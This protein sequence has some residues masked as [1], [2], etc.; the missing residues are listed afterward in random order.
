[1]SN[2]IVRLITVSRIYFFFGILFL[3]IPADAGQYIKKS[4]NRAIINLN[5]GWLFCPQNIANGQT[6]QIDE[7]KFK[8]VCLPHSVKIVRH[9]NIDTSAFAIISWYRR[10]INIPAEYKDRCFFIEFQGVSKVAEVFVNNNSVGI[11]KGAYTQFILDIT[12]YIKIGEDNIIAVRVDSRQRKDIPPE[13]KNVDYMIFGGIV[14]DVS[15]IITDPVHIDNVFMSC[16]PNDSSIISAKIKI[17]NNS[18][19]NRNCRVTAFVVDT[20]DS[21]VTEGRLENTVTADSGCEFDFTTGQV[22]KPQLWHPDHPYLYRIFTEIDYDGKCID[23]YSVKFGVRTISFNKTDG[24]FYINGKRLMLRGLNR[25]ETYPFIGRAASNR[26]Q[27]KDAEI[28]KY[29]LGCNTIRCSHYPQDPEFLDRC[30]EIGLM[31]LDEMPG[32]VYVKESGEWQNI[33]VKNVEEM[34][35]RDRNH[36]SI[37]SFGVRINESADFHKFY[38]K[39]NRISKT[40]DPTRPVHG[41]RVLDRGFP[42]EFMEDLWAQNFK[43]PD[44]SSKTMPWITTE[45]VGHRFRT[46]SWDNEDRLV[47][48]MLAFASVFDSAMRNPMLSGILGWTSFDYNS[49]YLYAENQICYHGVSDIFRIPKFAAYFMASQASLSVNGPMVYIADYWKKKTVPRDIWVVSNCDFVEL[50]VNGV[51][52]GK[53]APNMYFS[54][55][56]PLFLWKKVSFKPGELKAVGYIGSNIAATHVRK[57]PGKPVRLVISPDDTALSTGGDMTRLVITAVDAAGQ[58]VPQTDIS[59]SITVNGAGEFFGES[60]VAL[61]DGKTAFFIKTF[62]RTGIVECW[63]VSKTLLGAKKKIIVVN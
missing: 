34:I 14:R 53:Q 35:T 8:S 38:E 7:T 19:V 29:D 41:V 17:L 62:D 43:L 28:L 9:S 55:E 39:T 18:N 5:S 45:C 48:Q 4:C 12:H 40:L 44:S 23:E 47:S 6:A 63:A 58:V 22:D 3:T 13:G 54:L 37:I 2:K 31:V 52:I 42:D 60:P 59:V 21:I 50:F 30:D 25:H 32:W 27:R 61:E 36:P 56:H 1:M 11:H 15:L 33:A 26:L 16:A 10:H 51:S 57:T 46:H 20:S 24:G 49:P